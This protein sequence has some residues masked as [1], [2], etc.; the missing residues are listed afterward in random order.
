MRT[1]KPDNRQRANDQQ[2]RDCERR[3]RPCQRMLGEGVGSGRCQCRAPHRHHDITGD[4]AD[5]MLGMIA[6]GDQHSGCQCQQMEEHQ[7]SPERRSHARDV[8]CHDAAMTD[9][10]QSGSVLGVVTSTAISLAL[11]ALGIGMRVTATVSNTVGQ[12]G[13]VVDSLETLAGAVPTLERLAG[14]GSALEDL[15]RQA[16]SLTKLADHAAAL[17]ELAAH[18][19][20][21]DQL[22]AA[23]P[24]LHSI[25]D[26]AMA[27]ER[28]AE[29]TL[30][31]DKLV[32]SVEMLTPLAEAV[33]LLN[34]AVEQ[35][36]ATVLP[37]QGTTERIGRMV[38]RLPRK[39]AVGELP[40]GAPA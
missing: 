38:D 29:S 13:R 10:E 34:D 28:L 15:A 2:Q 36:N 19:V 4:Q 24:A 35:L 33:K 16:G 23:A 22:A 40:P 11:N 1:T 31:L 30:A 21:L 12:V 39:R 25:A 26:H 17:E 9:D 7:R 14:F 8:M 5:R 6:E 20:A 3:Q 27:L 32:I 18:A 37:L